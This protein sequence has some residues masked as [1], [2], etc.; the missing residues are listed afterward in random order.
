MLLLRPAGGEDEPARRIRLGD[1]GELEVVEVSAT[2][3]AADV[4]ALIPDGEPAPGRPR[5]RLARRGSGT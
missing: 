3:H 2:Q 4:R 1:N 5:R